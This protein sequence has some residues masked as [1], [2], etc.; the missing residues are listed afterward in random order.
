MN[1]NLCEEILTT[2]QPCVLSE[3]SFDYGSYYAPYIPKITKPKY[4]F[5][6]AKWHTVSINDGIMWRLSAEYIGMVEWCAEH[7]GD[8]PARPDAWSRWWVGSSV[9]NFRDENDRLLFLLRWS[10]YV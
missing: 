10:S 2:A 3:I 1:T 7:F 5:S 8:H 6:R 4:R 9:I